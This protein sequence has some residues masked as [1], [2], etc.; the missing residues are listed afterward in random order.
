MDQFEEVFTLSRAEERQRFIDLLTQLAAEPYSRLA[1][2]TTLRAD[3]LES[4]LQFSTLTQLIQT[5]AVFMPPLTGGDLEQAIVELAKRLGYSFESG[6]LGEILRDVGQEPGC[7]PLLQFALLELWERRDRQKRLLTRSTYH[8][9]G[10]V[11]G[12]LDHHVEQIYQRLNL[13]EQDWAKR[14]CLMLVQTSVAKQNTRRRRT[15]QRLLEMAVDNL[16]D[17]QDLNIAL[18]QLI[19][20]RLLVIAKEEEV[21][22]DL[23]HEALMEKWKRFAGWRQEHQEVLRLVN[24]VEEAASEWLKNQQDDEFL[25]M[26]GILTQVKERWSELQAYLDFSAKEFYEK[27]TE[28]IGFSFLEEYSFSLLHRLL[29]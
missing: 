3:F 29:R 15:K 27:S 7:L 4:C 12:V 5:Q 22:V 25:M 9:I 2:V 21:W 13:L 18:Q 28:F 20:G 10:S 1:V 24:R 8:Q 11:L 26:G 16:D 14:I 23:A 17:Q 19:D 6:L